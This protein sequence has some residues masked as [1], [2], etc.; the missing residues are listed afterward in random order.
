MGI[1]WYPESE[2]LEVKAINHQ[3]ITPASFD[4]QILSMVGVLSEYR[5]VKVGSPALSIRAGPNVSS[6][7]AMFVLGLSFSL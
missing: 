7:N 1:S 6:G 5:A 3:V 2:F 4:Y